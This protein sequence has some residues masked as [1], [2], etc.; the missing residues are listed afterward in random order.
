MTWQ[1]IGLGKRWRGNEESKVFGMTQ[2]F[3]FHIRK[4][5]EPPTKAEQAGEEECVRLW[6]G[7]SVT[8]LQVKV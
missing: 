1:V 8:E 5:A 4:K 2:V 7:P 3:S 6:A